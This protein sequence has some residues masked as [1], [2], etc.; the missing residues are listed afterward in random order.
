MTDDE[1]RLEHER[2]IAAI[3]NQA[4]E[5]VTEEY[6]TKEQIPD[7]LDPTNKE[8]ALEVLNGALYLLEEDLASG[9]SEP[10]DREFLYKRINALVTAI[11]W[12]GAEGIPKID[13]IIENLR[14][15]CFVSG[16]LVSYIQRDLDDA[17]RRRDELETRLAAAIARKGASD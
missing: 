12:V 7:Y 14:G 15:S 1:H 2:W 13:V 5:R 4:M 17:I 6:K 3:L 11:Y 9:A 8:G 10:G 16:E